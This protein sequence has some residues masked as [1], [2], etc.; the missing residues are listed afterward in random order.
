MMMLTLS[1]LEAARA[2]AKNMQSLYGGDIEL[3]IAPEQIRQMVFSDSLFARLRRWLFGINSFEKKY[4][5]KFG[6][7]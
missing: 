1:D 6:I 2:A 3:L 7:K 5:A 4:S